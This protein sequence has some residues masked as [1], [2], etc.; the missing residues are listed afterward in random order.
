MVSFHVV[1]LFTA[2]PVK[3][4]CTYIQQKLE[5]D[6]T[7]HSQTNLNINNIISLLDF[8]L[9]NNYFIYNGDTYRQI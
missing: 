8:V 3:K 5:K 2:I 7:L 1:S 4:A 9:S 6:E